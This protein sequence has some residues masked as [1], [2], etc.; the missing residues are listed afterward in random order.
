MKVT[1]TRVKPLIFRE[2]AGKE[3]EASKRVMFRISS[4]GSGLPSEYSTPS[5]LIDHFNA[6]GVPSSE[7]PVALEKAR[8][9]AVGESFEI[10]Y[11]NGRSSA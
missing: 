3:A 8:R 9:L 11:P 4:G 2:P 5:T 7:I 6:R 1:V 10:D